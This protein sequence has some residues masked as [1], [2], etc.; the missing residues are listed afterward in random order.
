LKETDCPGNLGQVEL[1]GVIACEFHHVLSLSY[2]TFSSQ[3]HQNA[4]DKT[5][6]NHL[7][8]LSGSNSFTL[9]KGNSKHTNQNH[10]DDKNENGRLKRSLPIVGDKS[11]SDR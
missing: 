5:G 2:I 10:L 4:A 9:E 8:R 3:V 11:H 6:N 1:F 7:N